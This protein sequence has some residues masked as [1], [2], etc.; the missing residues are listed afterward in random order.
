MVNKLR[1]VILCKYGEIILK[2][3]NKSTFE[4][5]LLREVKRRAKS[6]G[7]FS[8]RSMQSTV[9]IEPLDDE[10][11]DLIGEMYEA[12]K[13]IFGFAGIC[14][15]AS[16]EKN[17]DDIIKPLR[18]IFRISFPT[19]VLSVQ[20]QEEATKNSLSVLPKLPHR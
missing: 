11:N 6:V 3:A 9:Y 1:E 18:N 15:A 4:A 14:R 12:A 13:K 10:A 16:C 2:G 19:L 5:I 17:M 7:N 8:V 20:K